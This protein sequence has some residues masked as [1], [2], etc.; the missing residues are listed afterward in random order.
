MADADARDR[1]N[2][3]P[4]NGAGALQ[5]S[6]L[7]VDDELPNRRSLRRILGIRG[8]DVALAANGEEACELAAERVPDLAL[9]DV[10]MPG[11][12]GYEVCER[13]RSNPLTADVAIIMVTG[14]SGVED[15]EHAFDVGAMDYIRKPFN[16]REL[17][18]RVRN[19]L[20]LKHRT[21]ELRRWKRRM[22][23]ELELAGA[24]QQTLLSDA[25]LLTNRFEV[26][27]ARRPC[28]NIGGDL[29]DVIH[30]GGGR[31]CIYIGD[32]C[33]HGVAPA[34]ISSM[35]K[36]TLSELVPA[37]E[38]DGPAAICNE[39]DTRFRQFIPD[40]SLYAT[41]FL[42][43]LDPYSLSWHCMNCGHPSPIILT[44]DGPVSC[45][46]LAQKGGVPIGFGFLS[47]GTPCSREE[48]ASFRMPPGSTLF[49]Y[50]D[51]LTEARH[52]ETGEECGAGKLGE[53][54]RTVVRDEHVIRSAGEVFDRIEQAGYNLSSDD[55]SAIV[56]STFLPGTV[57]VETTIDAQKDAVSDLALRAEEALLNA[58]WPEDVAAGVRLL[59]MEHGANVI[60]HGGLQGSGQIEVQ[61]RIGETACR[62]WFRDAG[63][64]WNHRRQYRMAGEKN[65]VSERGRGL[66][67]L[68]RI[69]HSIEILR[70]GDT[71]VAQYTILRDASLPAGEENASAS[72]RETAEP[73]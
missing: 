10:M 25:P 27:I 49:A 54:V 55:C 11:M 59:V 66:M 50:T 48:E 63:R 9:V 42:G 43:I 65:G 53:I 28:L 17:V 70:Y 34:I 4:G 22:S 40:P 41:L 19:A 30:L 51:G 52:A 3:P 73:G 24:L 44:R 69:A 14:K 13:L 57:A 32:I 23:H 56:V 64:E 62:L 6:V 26:R 2:A 21:D 33:G 39:L 35:L 61:L 58:Q 1:R 16:P 36:G 18:V 20:D 67:I 46:P 5:G 15:I 45:E 72:P 31:V 71:N 47:G 8:C 38:R 12:D 7:V 29:F 68:D 60:D 37:Y